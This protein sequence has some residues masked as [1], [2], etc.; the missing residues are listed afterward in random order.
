MNTIERVARAMLAEAVRQSDEAGHFVE[1]DE[2]WPVVC[3][4]G[5]FDMEAISR[6]AIEAMQAAMV[7]RGALGAAES[8]NAALEEQT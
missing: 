7:Q 8:I 2:R 3:L 1:G 4:D 6:A 5:E